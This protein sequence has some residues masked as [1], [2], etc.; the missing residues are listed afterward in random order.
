MQEN[1]LT[2]DTFKYFISLP[3]DMVHHKTIQQIAKV[4]IPLLKRY[5]VVKAGIFGSYARG[6]Q[7]KSSDIDILVKINKDIS[8]LRFVSLKQELEDMLNS[9]VDLVEYET[10]KPLIK[11]QILQDEVRIL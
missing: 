8:L 10:L 6:E 7:K 11:E 5:G 3:E 4:S 9:K 1:T 2:L